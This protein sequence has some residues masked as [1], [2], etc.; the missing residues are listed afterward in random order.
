MPELYPATGEDGARETWSVHGNS[1]T[2]RLP[3][4][5]RPPPRAL[6]HPGAGHH[7]AAARR[8]AQHPCGAGVCV[9]EAAAAGRHTVLSPPPRGPAAEIHQR[10]ESHTAVE[11][12]LCRHMARRTQQE[13]SHLRGLQLCTCILVVTG[14]STHA[15]DPED[16]LSPLKGGARGTTVDTGTEN[17]LTP[18]SVWGVCAAD[19]SKLGTDMTPPEGSSASPACGECPPVQL[20]MPLQL[21]IPLSP[22]T[23]WDHPSCWKELIPS[24][25]FA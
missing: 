22:V 9:L 6:S 3:V 7:G 1:I 2:Y 19:L 23:A 18:E 25:T 10:P 4:F 12:L 14:F 15:C 13:G 11:M 8:A 20:E 16:L 17:L 21:R 5:L 24:G